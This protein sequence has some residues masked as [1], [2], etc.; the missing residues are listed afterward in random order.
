MIKKLVVVLVTLFV[1]FSFA[2]QGTTS[3]YSFYGIG[4]L[5]FKGTV[6]N[7]SMG[8][9]SIYTDSIHM[10]LRNPASYGG[11]NLSSYGGESRPVKFTV[12]G[13]SSGV[14]F[15]TNDS[16]ESS[17]STSFDYLAI[18]I[19]IGKLGVGLG[20]LPYTSVGYKI[21]AGDP[22]MLT[23]RYNGSGGLNKAFFTVGYQ[24]N[25]NFSIGVDANYDFG[26]IQNSAIEFVYDDEDNLVQYQ[27]REDNRSDL[28]GLNYN[29]G[30]SYKGMINEKLQLTSGFTYTPKSTLVSKNERTI[31]TLVIND[32]TG[33][34]AVVNS[35]EEDLESRGLQET[36]QILPSR[37]SFGIGFGQPKKWF[38]GAEYASQKTSQFSNRIFTIE[39]ATFEDASTFSFGGF[40]IP[41]YNSLSSYLQRVVYRAGIRF[42]NTGLNINTESINEFGISF[43]V[44]LP[45]GR[46]FSN[47]N[48]GFEIGK[49]GTTNQ[50]LIQENFFNFSLSLSLNDRWFVKRKYD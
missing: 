23:N 9:L 11:L 12:G 29:F 36:D 25:K 32:L 28:S 14:N 43:G 42:E 48:L 16:E 45:V 17:S 2:Q 35:I 20:L 21:G 37:V 3:P 38:M 22:E 27:S 31:A 40:Y 15:K 6:E 39:N 46:A 33:V 41:K 1:S 26:N 13:G 24:L 4:S 34:E 19:P 7:R 44:G 18:G 30:F 10:N 47:A 8:G 49:R 5:K 50:N